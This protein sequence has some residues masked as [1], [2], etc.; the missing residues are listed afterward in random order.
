[1]RLT[2]LP[3]VDTAADS[4]PVLLE[5]YTSFLMYPQLPVIKFRGEFRGQA[6]DLLRV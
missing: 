6:L 5:A 4:A 2:Q 1:M 3:A